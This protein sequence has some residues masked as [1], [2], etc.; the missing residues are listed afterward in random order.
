MNAAPVTAFVEVADEDP[1]VQCQTTCKFVRAGAPAP[2]AQPPQEPQQPQQPA[3]PAEQ[4]EGVADTSFLEVAEEDP[5]VQCQTTCKFVRA[6]AAAAAP[7]AP[8]AAPAAPAA[9]PAPAQ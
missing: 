5:T 2:Q 3:K 1:T 8:A 6:S 9:Q 4:E 7:A